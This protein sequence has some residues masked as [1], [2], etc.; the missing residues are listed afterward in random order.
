MQTGN[1]TVRPAYSVRTTGDGYYVWHN[2][3]G[4]AAGHYDHYNTAQDIC[5][6]M[7]AGDAGYYSMGAQ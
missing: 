1:N 4:T 2:P 6:A 7:N 5:A 3:T